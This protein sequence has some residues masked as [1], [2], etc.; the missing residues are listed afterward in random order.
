MITLTFSERRRCR[1]GF[2]N[3][4]FF[5]ISGIRHSDFGFSRR[6]FTLIELL[7][8]IAIIA[9]LAALLLPALSRAKIKAQRIQDV[10]NMKQM[11]LAFNMYIGDNNDTIPYT[12][13]WVTVNGP[14]V[15]WSYDDLL[16]TYLSVNLT[17]P[18][19]D[20]FSWPSNKYSKVLLCPLDH[21]PRAGIVAWADVIPRTYAMPRPNSKIYPA[22]GCGV[23]IAGLDLDELTLPVAK[24]KTSVVPD[25]S[26]T[27]MLLEF[28]AS[29]SYAGGTPDSWVD[30]GT[31]FTANYPASF[32]GA[33]Y[34]SWL[35]VDGHVQALKPINTVG[36]GTLAVPAGMWTLQ[37]GD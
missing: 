11:G 10:N 33:G 13:L 16:A 25:P 22:A 24:I 18:E 27:I 29:D 30:N 12:G 9:I 32:H 35:F 26:G 4:G 34:Y 15:R 17:Q 1:F 20:A 5:R 6:G 3:L 21:I 7:V 23:A 37:P 28:P 14:Q 31:Y 8:V 19:I 2:R 36:T